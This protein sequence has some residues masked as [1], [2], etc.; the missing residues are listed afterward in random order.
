MPAGVTKL[1]SSGHTAVAKAEQIRA[2]ADDHEERD[3]MKA[4]FI[5]GSLNQTR[6]MYQISHHLP[7]FEASFTPYFCDGP[8]RLVQRTGALDFTVLGGEFHRQ[9]VKFLT[10]RGV[11][12]DFEGVNGPYDLVLTCSDL[13]VP[14]RIRNS[15]LVLVQEGMTDPETLAYHLVRAL[16]LP[17]W[18][19]Q[20]STTGLSNAYD[21]FCVASEGYRSLFERKG[22]RPEKIR[23]TGIPNFDHCAAY[24]DN[25]F[26]YR[27]YVLVATSDMR[28]TFKFENRRK[29]IEKARRIADGRP[30]IFK[31][32]PNENWARAEREVARHA[33]EAL[34]F[35]EGNTDHMIANCQALVTRYSSVVFVAAALGK[36]IH[37]D[38]A[39]DTLK[40][41]LPW[42]NG[43]TSAQRIAAECLS[44]FERVDL[45]APRPRKIKA[46]AVPRLPIRRD[47]P[48]R[49]AG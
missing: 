3:R 5:C 40:S 18:L 26:P 10:E 6:M 43:G 37:S 35:A 21:L 12:F 24:L 49:A 30:L 4:L 20:T 33:P 38:L 22:V 17:R 42:Q 28:E 39:H 16:G 25:D 14:K 45:P 23:V 29:F 46:W 31:F 9:T 36:E 47:K 19:A 15:R 41:L 1:Q 13:I 32:H 48:R 7:Q 11:N 2:N 27:D 44:L 8:G 34:C